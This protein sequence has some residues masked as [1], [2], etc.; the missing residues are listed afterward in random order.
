[1]LVT[2]NVLVN[3]LFTASKAERD[4]SLLGL[5]ETVDVTELQGTPTEAQK[6]E[7]YKTQATAKQITPVY[8]GKFESLSRH[9]KNEMTIIGLYTS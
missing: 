1:M 9:T 4:R 3:T 8:R 6:I 7:F 2:T 5:L